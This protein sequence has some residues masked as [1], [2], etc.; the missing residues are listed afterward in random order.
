MQQLRLVIHTGTL[1]IFSGLY[2]SQSDLR[3][4]TSPDHMQQLRFVI[5]TGTLHIFSGLYLSQ[6]DLRHLTSPDRMQQLRLVIHTGT[7]PNPAWS[8]LVE[9]VR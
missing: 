5:H 9:A 7:L 8:A 4:L 3:H 6:S 2:L 1:R